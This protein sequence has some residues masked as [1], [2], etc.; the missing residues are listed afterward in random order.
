MGLEAIYEALGVSEGSAV[1]L[2]DIWVGAW[3]RDVVLEGVCGDVRFEVAFD[4]C[5]EMRWRVY[6][7]DNDGEPTAWVDFAAGRDRHR[8]PAQV[9]TDTFGLTLWYGAMIVQRLS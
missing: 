8:S 2:V 1:Q 7:H 4:D 5:R 6:A 3:G 9:L